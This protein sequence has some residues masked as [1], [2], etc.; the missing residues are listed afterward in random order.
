MKL[1]NSMSRQ[2]EEFKPIRDNEVSMYVCGPT[3]YNYVHIGNAR[4]IIIFDVLRRVFEYQGYQVYHMSNYT[5]VDDKIIKR[6]LE[7]GV[8]EHEISEKYIAAYDKVRSDL[9]ALTPTYKPRVTQ[10]MDQIIAFI[11]EL[12]EK[13]FAYEVNGD[14]YF[15]VDKITEYG[16]LSGNT[17][18][19]LKVGARIEENSAKESPLDFALWKKTD[20]GIKWSSPWSEGRP[21]WHTECVVM[22][23]DKFEQG[24]IDIHGGGTDLKFPHHEN[25]IA[26]SLALNNN[27]IAHTWMHNAM[28]NIDGAKMSKSVGNVMW[29][30]TMIEEYGANVIRWM[31]MSTHYRM[32]L[33]ITDEALNTAKTELDKIYMPIKQYSIKAQLA[34]QSIG[35]E[36]VIEYMEPFMAALNNDLTISNAMSEIYEMVK[37]LNSSLRVKEINYQE[38]G[39]LYTTLLKMLEI[40]GIFFDEI[41]LSAD[42]KAVFKQWNEAK[43]N[44][45][46]ESADK[47]RNILIERKLV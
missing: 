15:R 23:N 10:T 26:Q 33:N 9:H 18:D 14:V 46:Y 28:L 40:L 4:P 16:T 24:L 20:V 19:D 35:G 41:H 36:V 22:I 42:D 2:V 34:N 44:K 43:A 12:I 25:E 21:G 32:I 17:V 30:K 1:Y 38:A 47:Y 29:A 11:A 39:M 37:K 31:M 5:D 13:D 6:A 8:S 7:E 3:V 27:R 45:D